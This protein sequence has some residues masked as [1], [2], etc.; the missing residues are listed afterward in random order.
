VIGGG[1]VQHPERPDRKG[2]IPN[3]PQQ[4]AI[5]PARAKGRTVAQ[6]YRVC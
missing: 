2:L 4:I 3:A 5:A 6:L 1:R